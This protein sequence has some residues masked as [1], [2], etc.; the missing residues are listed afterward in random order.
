MRA[1]Y[2]YDGPV[3]RRLPVLSLA[4]L[5]AAAALFLAA[6][7][8]DDNNNST[9][10]AQ[11]PPPQTP[12]GPTG[13]TGAS[14]A[15]KQGSTKRKS[16]SRKRKRSSSG[17]NGSSGSSTA[18]KPQSKK[19]KNLNLSLEKAGSKSAQDQISYIA[20]L[21]V[22]KKRPLNE[23]RAVYKPKGKSPDAIAKA[24]SKF[25]HPPHRAQAA[26]NGCLKGFSQR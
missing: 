3:M 12:T 24:V 1:V 17:S 7:G 22:C 25:Y 23:I 8:G 11:T 18:P 21:N 20:A 26:Y 19:P 2:V 16:A 4:M 13:A 10:S 6:C 9:T 14:K 5:L 15:G